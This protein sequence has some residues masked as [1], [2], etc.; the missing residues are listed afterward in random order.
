MIITLYVALAP[1]EC[2]LKTCTF[3]SF[4]PPCLKADVRQ[5]PSSTSFIIN[6]LLVVE[7]YSISWQQYGINCPTYIGQQQRIMI[8]IAHNFLSNK[9]NKQLMLRKNALYVTKCIVWLTKLLFY[10]DC[11]YSTRANA[12]SAAWLHQN[13]LSYCVDCTAK[14]IMCRNS[15]LSNKNIV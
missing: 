10:W 8:F 15:T 14:I 5:S 3:C 1:L 4:R 11:K 2:R 9:I 12:I 6:I 13:M 7:F